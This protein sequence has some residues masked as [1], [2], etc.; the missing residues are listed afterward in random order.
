[1]SEKN[2]IDIYKSS[3]GKLP[4]GNYRW[5][6]FGEGFENLG[7]NGSPILSKFR[8][9]RSNELLLRVDALGICF[10]DIK[11]V[12]AGNKHI[13][14]IG[15]DLLKDPVILGHEASMTVAKVGSNRQSMFNVGERYVIQPDIYY[16]GK[17]ET[18]GYV[19]EGALQQYVIVGDEVIE[20]DEGCLL[21]PLEDNVGYAEASLTE[22]L[23]AIEAAY[24]IKW[25]DRIKNKGN[26]WFIGANEA[27]FD[28]YTINYGFEKNG[29][30]NKVFLT[31]VKGKFF[32]NLIA[33]MK[34]QNI[35]VETIKYA[36]NIEEISKKY[37]GGAGFDDIIILG[38]P[39]PEMIEA[40]SK[41]IAKG[42]LLALVSGKP[43]T[44][45][46]SIDA[47]PIHYDKIVFTGTAGTEITD[48]FKTI[49]SCEL[50]SGGNT[51]LVGAGGPM[52]QMHAQRA[53]LKPD[54]P[55]LVVGTD[56]DK[57]RIK[58]L[59][60]R[61]GK[62]AKEQNVDFEVLNP[63]DMTEPEFENK[64][65]QLTKNMKF[66]EIIILASVGSVIE[67]SDAWLGENGIMNIFAG[68]PK[69]TNVKMD[70]N[71]CIFNGHRW[72]GHSGTSLKYV[73]NALDKITNRTLLPNNSIAAV[74]GL[75][76]AL[77][78]LK[79]VKAG[80]FVGKV[81]IY[82]QLLDF[83]LVSMEEMPELYPNIAEKMDRKKLWTNEAEIELFQSQL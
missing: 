67:K 36:E 13:R 51:L 82:P 70:M 3:A 79:A 6:L 50:V 77:E 14:L 56:I 38:T 74:G 40:L 31:N 54:G 11:V 34:K 53:I 4:E 41:V 19:K 2:K 58:I 32:D 37:T 10:S 65:F 21:L 22:P 68:V 44:R 46:I 35:P 49:R 78:G 52:G 28:E 64:I 17:P 20:S 72:V 66:D 75:R 25:R 24:G 62:M 71:G 83:P 18:F 23:S 1:M 26:A 5:P 80:R 15:R 12:K 45:K 16:K 63:N 9:I 76:S 7:E 61:I 73:T 42:G 29:H 8:D 47:S 59:K 69:G 30:P 60:E 39:E 57:S 27:K 48:A 43:L 33:K 55:S 81:I